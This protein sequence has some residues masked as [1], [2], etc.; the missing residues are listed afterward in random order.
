MSA[1]DY[2]MIIGAIFISHEMHP[3]SRIVMGVIC[4]LIA[5]IYPML[6]AAS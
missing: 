1:S 3:T 4:V 2:F 5:T 6:K